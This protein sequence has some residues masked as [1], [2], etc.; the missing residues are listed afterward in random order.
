MYFVPMSGKAYG[1]LFVAGRAARQHARAFLESLGIRPQRK[2][3]DHLPLPGRLVNRVAAYKLTGDALLK[4]RAQK[5]PQ[6]LW[7]DLVR[8]LTGRMSLQRLTFD[9]DQAD[10][11]PA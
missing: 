3:F 6:L 5:L 2:A 7:E 1:Y 8:Y 4:V 11:S 10:L 9:A